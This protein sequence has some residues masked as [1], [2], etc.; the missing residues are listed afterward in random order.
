MD[1][2]QL[3]SLCTPAG[4]DGAMALGLYGGVFLLGLAGSLAHCGPMCG[5][6]VLA[7]VGGR[8]AGA[9]LCEAARWQ[10]GLLP[11]YHLGRIMTYGLLGALS[12]ALP[13]PLWL[14]P[15]LLLLAALIMAMMGLRSLI[16]QAFP[17][18]AGGGGI[19]RLIRPLAPLLHQ[20]GGWRAVGL[21]G[22]LGFIPC[23]LLYAVLAL[24]AATGKPLAGLLTM[25][26]FGLGTLPLLSALGVA[27]T[28]AGRRW[29]TATRR[30]SPWLLLVS[31]GMIGTMAVLRV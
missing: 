5:P 21:G 12:A 18:A 1:L 8:L 25:V 23:G 4:L 2:M 19:A 17:R 26:I 9:P 15:A 29:Q 7:Q 13:L 30:L 6:L 10:A 28:L 24:A 3:A 27:G 22:L 14:A 11:G 16:P 20:S 31:A